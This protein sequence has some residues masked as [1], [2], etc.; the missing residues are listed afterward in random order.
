MHWTDLQ[1]VG[2]EGRDVGA[3]NSLFYGEDPRAE[4]TQE[5]HHGLE[6][7]RSVGQPVR[8]KRDRNH[9]FSM[10]DG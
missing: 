9:H 10:W 1:Q 8:F 7:S 3:E 2:G 6:V 5:L 4:S